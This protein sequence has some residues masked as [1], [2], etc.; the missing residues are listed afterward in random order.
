MALEMKKLVDTFRVVVLVLASV[1][2]AVLL[3]SCQTAT[4]FAERPE[5]VG[6]SD[7]LPPF[8]A[9]AKGRGTIVS[10]LPFVGVP[11]NTADNIYKYIR[12][13]APGQNVLLALRLDEPATYR[14]KTYIDAVGG[15]TTMT[16]VFIVEIYDVAGTR[17]HRFVGQ[18]TGPGASGDPWGGIDSGTDKG[19]GYRILSGVHSWLTRSGA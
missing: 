19:I 13:N 6:G 10:F 14:V 9:P 15:S 3:A 2:A 5:L 7:R 8:T 12:E 11:V 18:E 16:F 4:G 17:V 1:S